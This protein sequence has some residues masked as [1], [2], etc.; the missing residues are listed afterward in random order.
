MLIQ[1]LLIIEISSAKVE[2]VCFIFYIESITNRS[3]SDLEIIFSLSINL[4]E[5]IV[6]IQLN[7]CPAFS[8][9]SLIDNCNSRCSSIANL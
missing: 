5:M 6:I 9:F 3:A 4:A 2:F 8:A 7:A 1:F